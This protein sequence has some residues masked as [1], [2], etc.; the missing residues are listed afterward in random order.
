MSKITSFKGIVFDMDGVL[1]IGKDPV[2]GADKIFPRL[3][4]KAMIVTNECRRTPQKIKEELRQMG[5][6]IGSTPILTAG[7]MTYNY[8]YDIINADKNSNTV[9][10]VLTIGEEGLLEVIEELSFLNNY[11]K[12]TPLFIETAIKKI[13]N[14]LKTIN[15]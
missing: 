11:K 2:K 3:Q 13:K 6:N 7:V 4:D 9:Y 10:N 14:L 12:I 5:I 15:T 1:R 8:L